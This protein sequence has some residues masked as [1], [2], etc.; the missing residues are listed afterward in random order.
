[1]RFKYPMNNSDFSPLEG[2]TL[3]GALRWRY[4]TKQFDAS[5]K[6]SDEQ[7]SALQESLHLAASSFGLQPWK[8]IV[9]T[10]ETKKAALVPDAWGQSQVADCS[11]L[12]VIAA[13][14]TMTPEDVDTLLQATAQ[15]RDMEASSLEGYRGMMVG[16]LSAR[17]PEF[18]ADWNARQCY[19]PLGSLLT[20]AA[21]MQV[22]ACPM[23][24]LVP[25][26][27]DAQLGLTGSDYTSVV[28]CALGFRSEDDKY[29]HLAKVRYEAG[30]VFEFI[31]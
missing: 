14:K 23:E 31:G 7:W 12:V 9:V 3:T 11:H 6:L 2:E 24:G 10:D 28:M 16:T 13:K 21:L 19:V 20:A 25:E 17:T 15:Q 4:A 30:D 8:F 27:F 26:K 1:M 18:I 22:D 5:K 29:A